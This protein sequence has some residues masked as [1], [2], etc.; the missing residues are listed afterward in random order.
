MLI[1]ESKSR[2]TMRN[3]IS[4]NVIITIGALLY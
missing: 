1:I 3:A 2:I 4:E